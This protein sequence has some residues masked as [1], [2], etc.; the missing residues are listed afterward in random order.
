[1]KRALKVKTF[2]DKI[3][4]QLDDDQENHI[5]KALLVHNIKTH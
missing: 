5:F 3:K 4:S 2:P 1:M